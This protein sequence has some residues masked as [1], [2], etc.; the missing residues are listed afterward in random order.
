MAAPPDVA[1][2]AAA[3]PVRALPLHERGGRRAPRDL[4]RRLR[5]LLAPGRPG[6][7]PG[8]ALP[9]AHDGAARAR[10]P[11]ADPAARPR[12]PATRDLVRRRGREGA[13]GHLRGAPGRD[14]RPVPGRARAAGPVE[15]ARDHEERAH[16]GVRATRGRADARERSTRPDRGR[17]RHHGGAA[18]VRVPEGLG[19][20]RSDLPGRRRLRDLGRAQPPPPDPAAAA[21]EGAAGGRST[22]AHPGAHRPGDRRG[23]HA[24]REWVPALPPGDLAP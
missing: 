24:R 23:G 11:A 4:A 10:R 21:I 15:D 6:E 22:R 5:V 17:G 2:G 13:G 18:R 8:R 1:V 12:R 20:E 14:T 19:R 3:R 16:H 7:D 9:A